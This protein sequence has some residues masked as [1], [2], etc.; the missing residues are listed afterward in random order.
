MHSGGGEGHSLEKERE[1]PLGKGE[2]YS[3]EKERDTF[4]RKREP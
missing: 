2:R 4:R 3:Q 1:T